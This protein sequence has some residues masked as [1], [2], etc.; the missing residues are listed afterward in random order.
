MAF[1][2]SFKFVDRKLNEKTIRLMQ[3]AGVFCMVDVDGFIHYSSQDEERVENELISSIRNQVFSDWI[4]LSFPQD[5]D[6]R[7]RNYMLKHDI[8]Y[9]EELRDGRLRFFIPANYRPHQWKL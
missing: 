4:I 1:Q 5:W 2:H 3:K 9:G 7:Y 8:P 6:E